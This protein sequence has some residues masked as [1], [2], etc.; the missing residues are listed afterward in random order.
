MRGFR[1]GRHVALWLCGITHSEYT[2]C[3]QTRNIP[4]SQ[5]VPLDDPEIVYTLHHANNR[6]DRLLTSLRKLQGAQIRDGISAF[7]EDTCSGC[8]R[9]LSF[10]VFV[11]ARSRTC[12]LSSPLYRFFH[13]K[14]REGESNPTNPL[15]PL[16]LR[17]FDNPS[18]SLSEATIRR[19]L[20]RVFPDRECWN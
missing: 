12:E 4:A 9:S 16:L 5:D 3:V 17:P 15:R 10:K 18:V 1:N 7:V 13:P 20:A 19:V 2:A 6:T 8:L 11:G 14:D